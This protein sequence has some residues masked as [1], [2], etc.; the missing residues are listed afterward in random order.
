MRTV[1]ATASVFRINFAC[2]NVIVKALNRLEKK[3]LLKFT[4]FSMLSFESLETS[5]LRSQILTGFEMPEDHQLLSNSMTGYSGN[6][7][8]SFMDVS[9]VAVHPRLNPCPKETCKRKP[10]NLIQGS[11]E[12]INHSL[13][14]ASLPE[15]VFFDSK[16]YRFT[17]SCHA[18]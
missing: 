7:I 1:T 13:A 17:K 14:L 10:Y 3:S 8:G 12:S 4:I 11:I 5:W 6:K 9:V 15:S 16:L 2:R 18:T